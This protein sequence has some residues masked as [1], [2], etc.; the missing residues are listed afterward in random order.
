LEP[1]DGDEVAAK[2]RAKSSY[3]KAR[4]KTESTGEEMRKARME[5]RGFGVREDEH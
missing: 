4:D 2:K 3:G 1:I 5:R